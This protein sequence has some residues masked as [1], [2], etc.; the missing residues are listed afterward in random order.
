MRG[1][2]CWFSGHAAILNVFGARKQSASDTRIRPDPPGR[3][4]RRTNLEEYVDIFLRFLIEGGRIRFELYSQVR[5]CLNKF[6]Q[7]RRN[8]PQG[9]ARFL[10]SNSRPSRNTRKARLQ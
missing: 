9:L 4:P 2:V 10:S 8:N 5:E 1:K 3:V 7:Q 6:A